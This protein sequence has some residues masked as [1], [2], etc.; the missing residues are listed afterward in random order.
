[1]ILGVMKERGGS[2]Y[3]SDLNLKFHKHEIFFASTLRTVHTVERAESQ[4]TR[5]REGKLRSGR[6]IQSFNI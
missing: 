2:M 6:E 5:I 4:E 1:M 3:L